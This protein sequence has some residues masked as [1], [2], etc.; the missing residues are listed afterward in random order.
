MPPKTHKN[1]ISLRDSS[2]QTRRNRKK[3]K[4]KLL[5]KITFPK[6]KLSSGDIQPKMMG[7]AN[8]YPFQTRQDNNKVRLTR[9]NIPKIK[10]KKKIKE[11]ETLWGLKVSSRANKNRWKTARGKIC[12]VNGLWLRASW[13]WVGG[14]ELE[15]S[16]KTKWQRINFVLLG[17][18][19]SFTK[20]C[21]GRSRF[22]GGG[23]WWLT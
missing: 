17:Q 21:R 9:A 22:K 1:K 12:F 8:W 20:R 13:H 15:L 19:G 16:C 3:R 7:E 14:S 18:G 10:S 5:C 23:G 11:K 2:K 6:S 4:T